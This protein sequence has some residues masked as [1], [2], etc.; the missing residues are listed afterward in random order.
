[1]EEVLEVYHQPYHPTE[2]RVCMDEQPV[3][4][5]KETRIATPNKTG[6]RRVYDH[7]YERNGTA[8]IFMFVEPWKGWRQ[9]NVTE[10]RTAIDWAHQ[11]RELVDVQFPKAERIHLILDNLNTHKKAS[12]YQAFPPDEA[13]RIARKLEF[14]YTP[15]HGSWLNMA[16]IEL[17]AMTNQCIGGRNPDRVILEKKIDA[18]QSERNLK[19]ST[20]NWK[21]NLQQARFKLK[22][23]YPHIKN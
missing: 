9:V 17:A 13:L 23:T 4:L 7:E 10:H 6:G 16:E 20:I 12:L 18:W 22:K 5:V 21:F 19:E 3:Q 11:I 2:P 8:N 1:M 14:H 15:K